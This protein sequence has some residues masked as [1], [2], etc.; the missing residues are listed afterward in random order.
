MSADN[1]DLLKPKRSAGRPRVN[2]KSQVVRRLTDATEQLLREC[3]HYD[4]TERKIAAAADTTVAM[5]H[6][7]FGNKNGLLFDI[8]VGYYDEISEKLKALDKIDP[9][10]DS[11]IG[12]IVAIVVDAYYSKYWIIRIAMSEFSRANSPFR[13]LFLEKYGS[14]G[15][16]LNC[17][18]KVF[19]RLISSGVF[20]QRGSPAYA[21]IGLISLIM[22]PLTVAPM[23]EGLLPLNQINSDGW[24]DYVTDI[25]TQ[26]ILIRP[27]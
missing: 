17:L 2:S 1:G 27:A 9:M 25:F 13:A 20:S 5:I 7:Y 19:E 26:N 12:D 24:S 6:Y 11:V 4:L 3:S 16:G 22:A 10:A 18:E 8:L 15:V 23:Y 14:R 21:A